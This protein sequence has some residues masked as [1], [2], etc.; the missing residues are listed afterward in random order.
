MSEEASVLSAERIDRVSAHLSEALVE[1]EQLKGELPSYAVESGR[2]LVAE[3]MV[4]G[5]RLEN[6]RRVVAGTA[7]TSTPDGPPSAA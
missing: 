5:R 4:I 3:V 7:R 6:M 1:L 2:F